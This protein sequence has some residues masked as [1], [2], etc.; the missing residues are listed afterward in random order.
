MDATQA[1]DALGEIEALRS[2]TRRSLAYRLAMVASRKVDAAFAR[3]GASEWD[4]AAADI[5][6][7]ETGGALVDLDGVRPQY[8]RQKT[9]SGP[10]L[11]AGTEAVNGVIELAESG[12]FLH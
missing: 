5:I 3:P 11:A 2:A 10:L 8:N 9:R 6:L 12:G 7:R 1:A 4:I